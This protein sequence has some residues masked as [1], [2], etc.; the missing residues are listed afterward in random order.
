MVG[1]KVSQAKSKLES[2][3]LS[4]TVCGSGDVVVSQ[5]PEATA[6]MPKGG[7]VVLYTDKD[8]KANVKVPKL[9]GMSPANV[10]KVAA[11]SG[12]NVKIKGELAQG[13]NCIS[14]SQSIG[15]GETVKR[16]TSITVEFVQKKDSQIAE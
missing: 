10:N 1:S 4:S 13:Q 3:G 8:D 14:V 6:K 12:L 15:E 2:L 7:K 9:I 16:G 11:E 5:I